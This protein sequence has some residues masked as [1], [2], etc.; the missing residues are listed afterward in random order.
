MTVLCD[1]QIE[2]M[3]TI[4]P[5]QQNENRTGKVS[6]GVSSYGYDV[7][8]GTKFKIFTNATSGGVAVIDPKNFTDDLFLIHLL[9][10]KE[11]K[12]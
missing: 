4:E 6:Y 7:R 2:E 3:I 5:F 9:N 12:E 10:K 1:K 8:V 11:F